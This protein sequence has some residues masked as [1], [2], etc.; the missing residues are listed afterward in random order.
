[1]KILILSGNMGG[2][3]NTAAKAIMQKAEEKG[4]T[5]VMIDTLMFLS[6]ATS[7]MLSKIYSQTAIHS[8]KLLGVGSLIADKTTE[9]D[10]KTGSY[11]VL[12]EIMKH[13]AKWIYSFIKDNAFDVVIATHI[14]AGQALSYIK[15]E[16][17]PKL[18]T[19]IVITDYAMLQFLSDT[20]LDAYFAPHK[21]LVPI[22]E[23]AVPGRKVLPTGIPVAKKFAQKTEKSKAREILGLPEKGGLVLIMCGSFGFGNVGSV[24]KSLMATLSEDC[25]IVVLCGRNQKL[26]TKLGNEYGESGRVIPLAFTDKVDVYMDACDVL[27]TK[28]G[29]LSVTEAAVKEIPLILS[30]PIPGW[31]ENNVLFFSILGMSDT[32]SKPKDIALLANELITNKDRAAEMIEKQRE[33]I[34]KNAADDI[35]KFFEENSE[36]IW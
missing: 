33:H 27:I 25:H 20:A 11:S 21:Y 9:M 17:M 4:H 6:P 15:H 7:N 30:K 22:Y 16:Y 14:F 1:M 19:G 23:E 2:G 3:H 29:G 18:K 12:Y 24:I 8:P 13:P 36:K 31:E 32:S 35:L 34:N 26:I 5:A 10:I 28:P